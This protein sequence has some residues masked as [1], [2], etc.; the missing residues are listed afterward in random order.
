M[1]AASHLGYYITAWRMASVGVAMSRVKASRVPVAQEPPTPEQLADDLAAIDRR[2]ERRAKA[3]PT[4]RLEQRKDGVSVKH[5]E[6]KAGWALMGEALGSDDPDFTTGILNQ[7]GNAMSKG[8]KVDVDRVNFGLAMVQGIQPRDQLE[9]MLATQMAS[10]H[11]ATMTFARRLN[12]VEN[13]P[14]QDSAARAL[15]QL[16]RTFAAQVDALKRYRSGGQQT[17]RVEHVH[18]HAGGQAVVGNVAGGR[19]PLERPEPTP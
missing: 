6:D 11:D 12:N 8:S 10:I 2:K 18:V 5:R 16:A 17:V 19:G 1:E 7:L 13:I 15:N 9:T 14:Q 3:P 4:M